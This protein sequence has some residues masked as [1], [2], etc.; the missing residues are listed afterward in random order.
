MY[1]QSKLLATIASFA[2]VPA[3]LSI[4][5]YAGEKEIAQCTNLA[6][7]IAVGQSESF[8]S[9]ELNAMKY[10]AACEASQ[11]ANKNSIDIGYS[12]FSL[13]GTSDNSEKNQICSKTKEELGINSIQYSKSKIIFTN[14]L[15]TIDKCLEAANQDWSVNYQRVQRDAVTIGLRHGGDR[16]GNIQQIA[17]IPKSSMTC[18]GMPTKFPLLVTATK[19]VNLTCIRRPQIQIING[20]VIESSKE[21][22]IILQL[23]AN[24]LTIT[25]PAYSGSILDTLKD[26]IEKMQAELGNLQKDAASLRRESG[27]ESQLIS[28]GVQKCPAGQVV[29]GIQGIDTDGGRACTS[30]ISEIKIFCRPVVD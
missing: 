21:A 15:R 5:V 7:E 26:K 29:V 16:G 23:G 3:I 6:R 24:P 11:S 10:F 22:T 19:P 18:K 14:A 2:L 25:I 17:I 9:I 20:T 27:T 4:P 28:G 30:C 8:S 13:G 1:N 12:A